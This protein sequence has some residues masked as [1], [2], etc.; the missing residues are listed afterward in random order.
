MVSLVKTCPKCLR[1]LNVDCF[2]RNAARKDGRSSACKECQ[3][4]YTNAHYAENKG[5]YKKKARVWSNQR[6]QEL[7]R[8]INLAK[9]KPCV[10][11][12]RQFPPVAMDL[13]HIRGVKVDDVSRLRQTHVHPDV[14]EAEIAKCDVRCAVCHRLKTHKK[15]S[16]SEAEITHPSEG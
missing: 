3:R 2:S 9:S 12:G 10:D 6:L 7:A 14:I 4:Q 5:Y 15:S 11:C 8:I 13:D 16:R 1:S